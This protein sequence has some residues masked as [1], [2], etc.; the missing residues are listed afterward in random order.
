MPS[1][2]KFE[3]TQATLTGLVPLSKR[4]EYFDAKQPGLTVI[5]HPS[6]KKTFS[7]YYR[8]KGAKAPTRHILGYFGPGGCG[9]SEARQRVRDGAALVRA[10]QDPRKPQGEAVDPTG[11]RFKDLTALYLK[12]HA[13][14]KKKRPSEDIRIVDKELLPLWG[15]RL[16]GSITRRDTA[17][18]LAGVATRGTRMSDVVR[19]LISKIF[20]FGIAQG[21]DEITSNPV[22]GTDTRH[23][24]SGRKVYP[25]ME[26]FKRLWEVW[27]AWIE[28]GRSMLGWQFQ[29]RALT[30]QRGAEVLQMQWS[31]L[32][33][34]H[35]VKPFEIRKRRLTSPHH[36]PYLIVLSPMALEILGKIRA[37]GQPSDWVFPARARA[38]QDPKATLNFFAAE[39]E[40]LC[41]RAKVTDFSP[42]RLRHW[43]STAANAAGCNP[44]WVERY[45]DHEIGGVAGIYNLYQYEV[46]K[47]TVAYAIENKVRE[48]LGREAIEMPASK[49]LPPV[50]ATSA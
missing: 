21:W 49:L 43:A 1:T 20:N 50:G 31:T 19:A 16:A 17:Q 10:G 45:I 26:E 11:R 9:L 28:E 41:A 18:L 27:D 44:D 8:V 48:A 24:G 6:G 22:I 12:L 46:E 33:G 35:W 38:G 39:T 13:L 25:T 3:F 30:A 5:V 15:D 14:P 29:L 42:H 34:D 40:E 23:V 7:H 36:D 4:Q 32:S 2:L 37:L 47:R